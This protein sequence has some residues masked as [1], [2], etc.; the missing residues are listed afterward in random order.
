MAFESVAYKARLSDLI[1]NEYEPSVGFCRESINVTPPAASAPVL[2]GTIGYRA[3]SLNPAAAYTVLDADTAL[4]ATNEF[5]VF[6][7][8]EYGYKE[9]FVPNAIQTGE[10]NAV[11]IKRGPVVLKDYYIKAVAQDA[12]GAALTDANVATLVELL[13]LQNIIVEKTL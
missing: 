6:I 10:Y 2:M 4:V 11:A 8:D 7:G 12:A 9:S 13:K 3:K 5:V 1:V